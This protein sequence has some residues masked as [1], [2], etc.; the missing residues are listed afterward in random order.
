MLIVMGMSGNSSV[1]ALFDKAIGVGAG[2]QRHPVLAM[3]KNRTLPQPAGFE[4]LVI[5]SSMT[6]AQLRTDIRATRGLD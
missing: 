3:E 6:R 5:Q 2:R 4:K 1:H